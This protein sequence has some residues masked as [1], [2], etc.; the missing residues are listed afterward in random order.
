M[1]I[2]GIDP[3]TRVAGYGILDVQEGTSL[4]RKAFA[5]VAAGAWKL[6]TNPELPA[7]LSMLAIEFRRILDVYKPTH[8]AVELSFL[9]DNP[10]TALLLGHSRGV[11]LSEAYQAGL[12]I[13]EISATEVKKIITGSGRA[14]KKSVAQMMQSLLNIDIDKLPY[15]ATDAIAIAYA[16]ALKSHGNRHE[17]SAL[18]SW[19][20]LKVEK[21]KKEFSVS[22]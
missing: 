21:E 19:R 3:G 22:S 4:H 15:D 7:R 14:Q 10:R 13:S 9:A 12:V 17:T 2:I 6:Y 11:I 1:R 18:T 16:Q 20:K 5:P 8:I